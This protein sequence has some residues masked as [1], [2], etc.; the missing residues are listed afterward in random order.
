MLD[1]MMIDFR[2][3]EWTISYNRTNT[4]IYKNLSVSVTGFGSLCRS[5]FFFGLAFYS[6]LQ[7]PVYIT[8]RYNMIFSQTHV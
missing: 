8:T 4:N 3:L 1:D 7:M 6:M 5:L 2:P